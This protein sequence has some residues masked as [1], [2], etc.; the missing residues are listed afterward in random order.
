MQLTNGFTM[1][2]VP[3]WLDKHL[4]CY[5]CNTTKSVKYAVKHNGSCF[6]LCNICALKFKAMSEN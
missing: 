1:Q 6:H 4:S 5:F 3:N 2:I